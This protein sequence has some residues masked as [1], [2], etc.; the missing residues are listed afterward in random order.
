MRGNLSKTGVQGTRGE[1]GDTPKIVFE[2]NAE[3]GEL[4]YYSDGVITDKEYVESNKLI[5]ALL[6]EI[7]DLKKEIQK[8]FKRRLMLDLP[9]SSWEGSDNLYYQIVDIKNTTPQSQVDIQLTEE[10][11]KTFRE[12]DI[13]FVAENHN[14]TIYIFCVGQKPMNDYTIQATVMEVVDDE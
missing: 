14:G 1:K 4:S 2:Y 9:S 7:S 13:V 12:K 5:Q 8:A 6:K 10:Q 3:T 11:L